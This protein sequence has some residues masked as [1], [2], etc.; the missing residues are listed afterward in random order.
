MSE[1]G[2]RT[3]QQKF[4]TTEAII[5]GMGLG[6]T[7]IISQVMNHDPNAKSDPVMETFWVAVYLTMAVG[8]VAFKLPTLFAK[9]RPRLAMWTLSMFCGHI[10]LFFDSFA[11]VL[12]LSTITIGNITTMP[13]TGIK[14]RFSP[15]FNAF[16][17]KVICAFNALTVGGAFFIGELWGLPY[18]ISSGFDNAT[19]GL[20][21]LLVLTP[22]SALVSYMAA[23]L[24]PVKLEEV[25]FDRSQWIGTAEISILLVAIIVTHMPLA[26]LGGLLVYSALTKRTVHLLEKTLHEIREGAGNALGLI[27]VA[28]CIQQIPGAKSWVAEHLSGVWVFLLAAVSSPF[29]GAMTPGAE[30]NIALF[31]ENLSYIMLGAPL[32]VSSSLVAIVVFRDSM[33]QKD[34]PKFL[35]RFC[36]GK[37]KVMDEAVAYTALCIP[38]TAGLGLCLWAANSSG[39]F[40]WT[41]NMIH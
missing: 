21:L 14:T 18:Y 33:K 17:F 41:Y 11:V 24:F 16:A 7:L 10:S 19:A 30:G 31:Y 37:S 26:C 28:L 29:A 4:L 1:N 6:I 32:F 39:L 15:K 5:L 13:M 25:K 8:F 27:L 35:Q 20:P 36:Y 3:V 22:Y 38:M 2:T 40:V 23:R 12:L 34:L 9:T